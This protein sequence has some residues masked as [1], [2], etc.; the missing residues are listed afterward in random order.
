MN[1]LAEVVALACPPLRKRHVVVPIHSNVK[2]YLLIFLYLLESHLVKEVL[3][4]L[5]YFVG[6]IVYF[7]W[8]FK[9][10]S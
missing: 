5:R 2:L 7:V 6:T 9:M 4:G 10:H 8:L 3:S 1:P